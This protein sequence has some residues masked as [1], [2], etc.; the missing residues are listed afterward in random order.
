ME[1]VLCI[2]MSAGSVRGAARRDSVYVQRVIF[3]LSFVYAIQSRNKTGARKRCCRHEINTTFRAISFNCDN[4]RLQ[5]ARSRY[6]DVAFRLRIK[7]RSLV[8]RESRAP[9]IFLNRSKACCM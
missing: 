1:N 8:A 6:A 4:Q 5:L 9:V 7:E 2:T 3:D